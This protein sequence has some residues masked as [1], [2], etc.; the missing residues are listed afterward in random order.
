VGSWDLTDAVR[1]V[2]Q[3]ILLAEYSSWLDTAFISKNKRNLSG[4]S[5]KSVPQTWTLLRGFPLVSA[6]YVK[7]LK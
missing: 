7:K 4:K 1:L 2:Q 6:A 5:R 3:V